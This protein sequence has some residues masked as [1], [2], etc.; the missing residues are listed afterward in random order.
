[1]TREA[2]PP[3]DAT[4]RL[5]HLLLALFGVAALVS[6][7]F[8]G[9]YR[10]AV[11][12]GFDI[13]RWIGLGMALALAARLLWGF[14]GPKE[15]RFAAWLPVT[16][17]R[18][19]LVGEDL[20]ALARLRLPERAGHEGLAG[21]VQAV[22]LAAFAWMAVSGAI[23]FAWLEPGARVTGWLSAV[24]ELHEGGQVVAI[25]YVAVH[26]GAVLVHAMAGDPVWRRMLPAGERGEK[27]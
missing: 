27:P 9:D 26:A 2:K 15:V 14:V 22:G 20:A 18:L 4:T 16:R 6:G 23:L 21:L 25:A 10:R 5:I 8:A 13:H 12:T 17:R 7:Q 19:A 1:M 24:K 3:Y 11:H